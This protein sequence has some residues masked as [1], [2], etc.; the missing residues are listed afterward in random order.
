LRSE[1]HLGK[2]KVFSLAA[3]SLQARLRLNRY[4]PIWLIRA[5]F[6]A[7]FAAFAALS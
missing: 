6:L 2:A 4:A 3:R 7:H 1:K 5:T